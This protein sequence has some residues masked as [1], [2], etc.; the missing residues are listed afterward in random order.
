[1][2]SLPSPP[3]CRAKR[4]CRRCNSRRVKCN[5]M[6]TSPCD[7]CAKAN[8]PCEVLES[9]R[10]KHARGNHAGRESQSTNTQ[11]NIN[12]GGVDGSMAL[13]LLNDGR[14][15]GQETSHHSREEAQSRSCA[16]TVDQSSNTS[17]SR[18]SAMSET[19]PAADQ[20]NRGEQGEQGE[21][22]ELFLGESA[23]LRCVYDDQQESVKNASPEENARLKFRLPD[24]LLSETM[25]PDWEARRKE[26]RISYL[27]DD[28][29]FDMPAES[30]S[31]ML[32]G[33]YFEW[34]HPCFPVLDRTDTVGRY[35]GGTLS[36]LLAQAI[37]SVA[38]AHCD[39]ES[40]ASAGLISRQQA[41]YLFYSRAKD[42]YEVDY[43]TDKTTIILA[44]FLMSFWR[45]GRLLDKH[46]RHWLG[47]AITVAQSRAM[48]RCFPNMDSYQARLRRRVWWS[49]YI[50]ECQ[51]SAALGLPNRIRNSDC[52]VE[53]L[54][55]IDV[56]ESSNTE[57]QLGERVLLPFNPVKVSYVV[58]MSKLAR[59]LN[60]IV[61]AE[62][63]PRRIM[64]TKT[65]HQLKK[66]LLEWERG[67]PEHIS[68]GVR[69]GESLNLH[70]AMLHLAYNN[71]LI[72]LFR[73]VFIQNGD[74]ESDQEGAT[75]ALQAASRNTSMTEDL[76]SRGLIGH[77]DIHL[78]NSLFNTLCIH[79]V[80]LRR[81]R[82]TARSVTEHRA[83]L[84][85]LALQE[86][87]NTWQVTV[88]PLQLRLFFQALDHVTAQ[89]LQL[90]NG[91]MPLPDETTYKPF[92][93]LSYTSLSLPGLWDL[94]TFSAEPAD[95]SEFSMIDCTDAMG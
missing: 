23:T 45:S 68:P 8:V 71:A 32:F 64:D 4:A 54:E 75:M 24:I 81:S 57:C 51:C 92:E 67:I 40:L 6:S 55:P 18:R 59:L 26:R 9:R 74:D 89:R 48:H 53:P 14:E 83:R 56:E 44:L 69:W 91:E 35:K 28:G 13:P 5:V 82:G 12:V 3:R 76:L 93:S 43:E 63:T 49:I 29:V 11:A 46:T 86:L 21:G 34:F 77:G 16:A 95:L 73:N 90:D 47:I 17:G 31:N 10:G 70:A 61:D 38:A 52:D 30:V 80:H 39:D 85:L 50:R 94:G 65:R 37:F 7:N 42:L 79:V 19:S 33:A 15:T 88:W 66:R 78:I 60:D 72:L 87:Q 25:L 20:E 22:G 62:Y 58:E 27:R 2:S 36:P 41:R 84:C 1:M